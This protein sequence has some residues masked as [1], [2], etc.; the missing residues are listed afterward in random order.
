MT[1]PHENLFHRSRLRKATW[2]V[3]FSL[4]WMQLSFASH[5]FDHVGTSIAES[6]ELCV[7]MDRGDDALCGH[8]LPHTADVGPHEQPARAMPGRASLLQ[9]R[10]FESRA[11]PRI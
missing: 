9:V 10:H 1:H 4:A 7:H 3:L 5:Q 2:L 8:H 6:C 11:P